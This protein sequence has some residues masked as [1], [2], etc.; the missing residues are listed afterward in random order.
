MEVGS[1]VGDEVETVG[2]RKF[3]LEV[4]GEVYSRYGRS[5][6]KYTKGGSNTRIYDNVG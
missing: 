6:G 3:G 1:D 5:V 2:D 4:G